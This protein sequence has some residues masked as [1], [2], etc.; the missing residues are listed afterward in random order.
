MRE[1]RRANEI[2]RRASAFF[3]A[4]LDRPNPLTADQV[5]QVID[6]IDQNKDE[7]GV[8]PIC[9]ELQVAPAPTTPPHPPPVGASLQR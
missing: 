8:E 7:L 1:L 5:A 4:E 6:F 3:A 2:L 9:Q